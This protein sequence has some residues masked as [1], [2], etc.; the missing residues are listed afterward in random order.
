MLSGEQ[1]TFAVVDQGSPGR[2]RE[3]GL[4]GAGRAKE[5]HIPSEGDK[6]QGAQVGD[7]VAFE[8]AG[9]VEVEF[10]QR[11][12]GRESGG[13]DA[14]LAAVGLPCGD[15]PSPRRPPR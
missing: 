10:L 7:D 6:A 15:F 5:H 2:T 1:D 3:V 11:L 12:A 9:V 4:A 14:A 13:P 8:P